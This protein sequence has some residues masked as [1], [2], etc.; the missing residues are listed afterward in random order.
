MRNVCLGDEIDER[1]STK[2][3]PSYRCKLNLLYTCTCERI[4]MTEKAGV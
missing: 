4:S 1:K 3:F 2:K